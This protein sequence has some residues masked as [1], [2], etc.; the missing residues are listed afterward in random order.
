MI[1]LA[2]L[3]LMALIG[4]LAFLAAIGFTSAYVVLV[5]GGFLLFMAA[6]GGS[7]AVR[8]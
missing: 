8:R 1:V 3:G 2:V 7:R 6:Y 5:T 4:A